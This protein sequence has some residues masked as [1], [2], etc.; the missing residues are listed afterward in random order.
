MN[1]K[2][3]R[4]VRRALGYKKAPDQ[5]MERGGL[6]EKEGRLY[7]EFAKNPEANR[8]RWWKRGVT[9]GML[10]PE[11]INHL[12]HRQEPRLDLSQA[13]HSNGEENE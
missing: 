8:Y 1:G 4:R 10:V 5:L 9:S 11:L 7:F 12:G 2:R 3:S 13:V 6:R